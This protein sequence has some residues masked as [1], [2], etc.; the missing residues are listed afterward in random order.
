MSARW[1]A[2]R[3]ATG[4]SLERRVRTCQAS[5]AAQACHVDNPQSDNCPGIAL[6]A[7]T[8]KGVIRFE[9]ACELRKRRWALWWWGFAAVIQS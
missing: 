4:I 7:S 6:E 8:A 3:G 9:V 1:C 2:L 5:T